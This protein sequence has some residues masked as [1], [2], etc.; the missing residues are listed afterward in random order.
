MRPEKVETYL[1]RMKDE[2]ERGTRFDERAVQWQRWFD[3]Q[4][5]MEVEGGGDPDVEAADLLPAALAAE[6]DLVD[7]EMAVITTQMRAE[8][9]A[10]RRQLVEREIAHATER[11]QR[12][13]EAYRLRRRIGTLETQLA[14]EKQE[15]EALAKA[16]AALDHTI[17]RDRAH[18]RLLDARRT[19]PRASRIEL[20]R[21]RRRTDQLLEDRAL[22]GG[23]DA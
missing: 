18:R 13:L 12:T 22:E 21:A 19:Y 9:G 17:A 5:E 8:N 20:E 10:L 4:I 7:Q 23:F 11:R 3:K 2:A 15:R 16:V 6:H 14:H 1:A